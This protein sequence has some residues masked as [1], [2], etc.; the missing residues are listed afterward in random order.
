M[1]NFFTAMIFCFFVISFC[2]LPMDSTYKLRVKKTIPFKECHHIA[3]LENKALLISSKSDRQPSGVF[4][5]KKNK[6][7]DHPLLKHDLFAFKIDRWNRNILPW[8]G[9]K[10]IMQGYNIKSQQLWAISIPEHTRIIDFSCQ[11]PDFLII[12]D[13]Y[14]TSYD[15]KIYLLNCNN[16][17]KMLQET[18]TSVLSK[19]ERPVLQYYN[20]NTQQAIYTVLD[21]L[22]VH[23]FQDNNVTIEKFTTVSS[24]RYGSTYV[25]FDNAFAVHFVDHYTYCI[26]LLGKKNMVL[27]NDNKN[28]KH[29]SVMIHPNSKYIFTMSCQTDSTMGVWNAKGICILEQKSPTP[30]EDDKTER[31]RNYSAYWNAFSLSSCGKYLAVA[32]PTQCVIF[33]VPFFIA[34]PEKCI[35][36]LWCLKNYEHDQ[37]RL[38]KDIVNVL[39]QQLK[40]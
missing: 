12:Q 39:F 11:T 3:F 1:K 14:Y 30:D 5:W 29:A 28:R 19:Y 27:L 34:S 17:S 32:F 10:K 4:D 9:G 36:I 7:I 8:G 13:D 18:I 16:D 35:E 6:Q 21:E 20:P 26:N 31:A 38:P 25:S 23:D 2:L 33:K 37:A 15:S 22:Y 40:N 24:S